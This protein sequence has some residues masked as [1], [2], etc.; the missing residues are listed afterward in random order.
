[1]AGRLEG[2]TALILGAGS[3]GEGWG[4]GRA[5]AVLFAREGARVF[6]VDRD[7][8]ALARTA[9]VAAA[10]GL[11]IL[12]RGAAVPTPRAPG[13]IWPAGR[14][15]RL[16]CGTEVTVEG[17]ERIGV[18]EAFLRSLGI[19]QFRVRHH[20][21]VARI[22]VEPDGMAVLMQDGNRERAVERLKELGYQHVTL[23][24][25][26]FRSGSMNET[27]SLREVSTR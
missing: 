14:S 8:A 5:T 25:A 3:V 4:N 24:L 10:R 9:G 17:R 20:G 11:E 2:K 27:L 21:D 18:A 26:G 1:M 13:P 7:P 15:A 19:R 16:P 6:G 12:A 22:E 23:D